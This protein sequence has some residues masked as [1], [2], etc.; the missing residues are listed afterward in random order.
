MIER[1]GRRAEKGERRLCFFARSASVQ[2]REGKGEQQK[3][4]S[5]TEER[6]RVMGAGRAG[7]GGGGARE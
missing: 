4:A 7:E 3:H 2:K 6:G 5:V 1:E